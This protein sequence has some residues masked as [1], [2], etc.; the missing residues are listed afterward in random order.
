MTAVSIV[1]PAQQKTSDKLQS[2]IDEREGL[3]TKVAELDKVIM[4]LSSVMGS[5]A[6]P[7]AGRAKVTGKN[8]KLRPNSITMHVL[9]CLRGPKPKTSADIID[10]VQVKKPTTVMTIRTA[11]SSCVKEG[12]VIR[13]GMGGNLFVYRLATSHDILVDTQLVLPTAR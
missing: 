6:K 7:M 1:S 9:D 11:L 4:R 2:L 5:D 12:S 3:L 10:Y 13:V 8:R